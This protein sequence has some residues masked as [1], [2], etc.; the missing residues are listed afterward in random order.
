MTTKAP[1][2]PTPDELALTDGDL[3]G[4]IRDYVHTYARWHGRRKAMEKFGVSRHTLWRFLDRGHL[5][6]AL[7]RAVVDAVGGSAEAIDAATWAIEPARRII[8]SARRSASNSRP[9]APSL[10][11]DLEDALLL[12]CAAPLATVK[13][14][15]R[16]GRIPASTLRD[17]L[18]KLVNLGLADSVAHSLGSL[19]PRPQRRYFPTK[20]GIRAG[21]RAENGT[22]RFLSEYPVSR[23]WFRLLTE[24]LDAVAVLYHVAALIADTDAWG[25]PVRVDHY[26]QGPYD[27]LVTLPE[28]RS[29]GIV[30]QGATLSSPNLRYRLRTIENLPWE[31]RPVATLVLTCSDQ[32]NRRAVRT[33][34]S[35]IQHRSFFVATEGEQLAG[36]HRAVVWQ[37]CGNGMGNNPPVKIAPE[38]SLD[39]IVAWM[40]RLLDNRDADRRR[41]GSKTERKPKPDPDT[42]YPGH[43][44]AAMPE[45]PEQ[46]KSALA[47]QL[48]SAETDTLDLLAAWPLCITEQLA[49]L[50]GGVTRRRANQVV[51]SLTGHSLV[52]TRE[53]RHVL[54]DD[55]LRCLAHR[56]RAAVRMAL[57]R[58]SARQRRRSRGASPV[59]AGTALRAKSSQLSHQDAITG[60]AAMLTAETARS[61]DCELLELLPTSRSSIGYHYQGQDYVVHPD[62]TFLLCYH[63]DCRPYFLEVERRAVTPKR[64]RA[65]L[66]NYRRY[67]A[68]GW[69]ERDHGG[70][71]PLVLFVFETPEAEEAFVSAAGTR[72]RL[73]LF[74]SDLELF[75]E[76]GVSGEVWRPPMPHPYHRLPLHCLDRVVLCT[77]TRAQD[78]L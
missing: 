78:F 21:A 60:F 27:L 68:S 1:P 29:L 3:D 38:A 43:L 17:R 42:L 69:P 49:G 6:R 47:V 51:Q 10:R 8:A 46:V 7:P 16:F 34:G 25:E 52:R 39:G 28:G 41:R 53:Q 14:L 19:G 62:A 45:L 35:P 56:D 31:Q 2:A 59:I 58:W 13:E 72:H 61:R 57:G 50:M 73:P 33:L 15:A 70:L 37:Q 44:R 66:K 74:T 32:A 77:E 75:E 5:G 4:A 48:S 24:R 65:R 26:R 11:P 71:L 55:G 20:E 67:F 23:Q 22:E 12:L 30:R 54:T 64:V 76:R 9:P 63:G 18:E 40:G 36:D